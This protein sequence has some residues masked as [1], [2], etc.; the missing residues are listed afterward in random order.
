MGW[1]RLHGRC[2]YFYGAFLLCGHRWKHFSSHYRTTTQPSS[3]YDRLSHRM[4]RMLV[5][6]FLLSKNL[7][8]H[9]FK[10]FSLKSFFDETRRPLNHIFLKHEK[11]SRTTKFKI[12]F[13]FSSSKC[14]S[15]FF[16]IG[17]RTNISCTNFQ[18]EYFTKILCT[19]SHQMRFVVYPE[20]SI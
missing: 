17:D 4:E 2:N 19:N 3:K 20:S 11:Y 7:A 13:L 5:L 15:Y 8:R 16:M 10:F 6:V 18:K 12:S 9:D 14:L 1:H